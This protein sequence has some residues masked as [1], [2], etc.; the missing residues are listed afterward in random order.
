[1]GDHSHVFH[2]VKVLL[3]LWMQCN[4]AL[5]GGMYDGI[6]IMAESYGVLTRESTNPCESIWK[7]LNHIISGFDGLAAVG[8]GAGTG[9]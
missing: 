4:G 3:D 2:F 6:N 5:H 1:M 9:L 8:V 7:L